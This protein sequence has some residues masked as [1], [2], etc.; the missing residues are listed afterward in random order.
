MNIYIVKDTDIVHKTSADFITRWCAKEVHIVQYDDA[1]PIVAVEL[2][3]NSV[4]Y[5]LPDGYEAN[6]R[7]GKKDRT[8]IYKPVL[9]CN[10]ER[11]T[12]YFNVDEQMSLLYGKVNPIIEL[13]YN[14]SVVGSSPIPFVVDRNP[15]QIGDIQSKSDYPAIVERLSSAES[16][17]SEAKD[18]AADVKAKMDGI[19]NTYAT[20]ADLSAE[21]T[22]RADGDATALVNA[23]KYTDD[24][25]VAADLKQYATAVALN[26]EIDAR[27]KADKDLLSD[28]NAYCDGAITKLNIGAYA[29]TNAL[30]EEATTRAEADDQVLKSA[31]D[32]ADS[33]VIVTSVSDSFK[34]NKDKKLELASVSTDVIDNGDLELILDGGTSI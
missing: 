34:I 31:K 10:T 30:D 28:A 20:I 21:K 9:G 1:Q 23:K 32:Y 27:T 18:I 11:N 2:F 25:L 3:M 13:T 22:N 14:G 19:E 7:F 33:K 24:A 8:F 16:S 5:I 29:T 15:V 4:K 12:V 6:L 17:A 26:N